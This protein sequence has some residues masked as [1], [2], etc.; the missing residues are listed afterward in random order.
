MDIEIIKESSS[1]LIDKAPIDKEI[2]KEIIDST[3]GIKDSHMIRTRKS[4]FYIC[5][6]L[7]MILYSCYSLNEAHIISH[8]V[9]KK[10]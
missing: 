8:N 5:V 4:L 3:D 6:D 10:S 9:E 2:I 1:V 7:R